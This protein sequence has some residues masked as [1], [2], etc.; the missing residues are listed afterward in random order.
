M[1]VEL[2]LVDGVAHANIALMA[3]HIVTCFFAS[4]GVNSG[5]SF[6][7][8]TSGSSSFSGSQF[9]LFI[10]AFST[11]HVLSNISESHVFVITSH[12]HSKIYMA[13][14]SIGSGSSCLKKFFI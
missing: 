9:S 1:N 12:V 5:V 4:S 11:T 3:S 7:A 6:S 2:V 14:V 10:S 8:G 13:D